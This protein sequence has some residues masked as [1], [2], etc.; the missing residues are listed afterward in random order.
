MQNMIPS[1]ISSTEVMLERWKHHEGKEI[2][3]SEEFRLLTSD[4]DFK[5]SF[6][7]I[8]TCHFCG[9]VGHIRPNCS[10]LRQKPKSE[11]RFTVRNTDVPKFVSVFH[12]YGV[13]GHIR[14]NCH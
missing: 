4:V 10:L 5:D 9:I 14:S 2:E 11:T 8:P 13:S 1:M 6:V 3:V 12:F 7:F